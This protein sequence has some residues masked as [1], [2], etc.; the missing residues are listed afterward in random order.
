VPE[1]LTLVGIASLVA[2][3]AWAL[4]ARPQ[5]LAAEAHAN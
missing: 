4:R 3:V 5:P 2:G 1:S